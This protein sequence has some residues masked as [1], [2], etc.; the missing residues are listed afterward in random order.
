MGKERL[1]LFGL[2]LLGS[3]ILPSGAA[4][5]ASGSLILTPRFESIHGEEVLAQRALLKFKSSGQ[6]EPYGFYIEG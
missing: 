2:L 3:S 4:E 1:G 5:A 6:A